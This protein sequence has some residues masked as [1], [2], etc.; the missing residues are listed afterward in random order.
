MEDTEADSMP[1]AHREKR[2]QVPQAA[3]T[4]QSTGQGGRFARSSD[5]YTRGQQMPCYKDAATHAKLR[6]KLT[7]KH[8]HTH[9]HTENTGSH[10]TDRKS[11]GSGQHWLPACLEDQS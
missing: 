5:G 2:L 7:E 1:Q 4:G 6:T 11:R 8:T 3:G 10:W 9:T